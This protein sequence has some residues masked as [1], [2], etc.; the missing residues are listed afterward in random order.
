MRAV[1]L[2]AALL[3]GCA[4]AAVEPAARSGAPAEPAGRSGVPVPVG[5]QQ[6]RVVR[7][8]DGDTV[9]LRGR[10]AGPLPAEP[11]RVRLLLID[12]PEVFATAE[13]FGQQAAERTA[14][15]L[16]AGAQVRVQADRDERD[17]FDRVLL[18]VW[19]EDGVHVGAEL[20][21]GGHATVLFLEPNDRYLD[22]LEAAQA[23]ARMAGRGLWSACR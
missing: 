18:H 1:L 22:Q 21:R 17:R 4:G 14:E 19:T 7:A 13:C 3:A 15:L 8:V 16:P 10:G 20:L 9:V 23:E 11:T 6:A 12:T 2:L 5:A